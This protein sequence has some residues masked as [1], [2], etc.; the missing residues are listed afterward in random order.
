MSEGKL[1]TIP[2]SASRRS[3]HSTGEKTPGM[4]M[5]ERMALAKLP[6]LSITESPVMMSVATQQ[7]GMGS[8]WKSTESLYPTLSRLKRLVRLAPLMTPLGRVERMLKDFS[9]KSPDP[10]GTENR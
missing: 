1:F 5:L 10:K 8:W 3:P 7:K 2:P 4:A 6:W 9:W